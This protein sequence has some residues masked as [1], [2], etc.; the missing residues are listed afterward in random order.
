MNQIMILSL[1][2]KSR[3]WISKNSRRQ[4]SLSII[5]WSQAFQRQMPETQAWHKGC[6][7]TTEGGVWEHVTE[8]CKA[9]KD[10]LLPHYLQ[11]EHYTQA[12]WRHTAEEGKANK[13]D[14]FLCCTFNLLL[15]PAF[16]AALSQWQLSVRD[17]DTTPMNMDTNVF[18]FINH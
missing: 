1:L 4:M 14:P 10:D 15:C 17:T 5:L 11:L 7:T 8:K 16:S 13:D 18:T 9:I 2:W 12:V 3:S 6:H